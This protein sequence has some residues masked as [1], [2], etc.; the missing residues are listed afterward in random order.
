MELTDIMSIDAW[1][2]FEKEL[3]RF[4]ELYHG[5]LVEAAS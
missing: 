4:V 1:E 5:K 3:C 2:K